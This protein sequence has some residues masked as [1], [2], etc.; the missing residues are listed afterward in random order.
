MRWDRDRGTCS[1]SRAASPSDSE[2]HALSPVRRWRLPVGFRRSGAQRP[3]PGPAQGNS[4]RL[5]LGVTVPVPAAGRPARGCQGSGSAG[6]NLARR[7]RA[8]ARGPGSTRRPRSQTLA[9]G[10]PAESDFRGAPASCARRAFRVSVIMAHSASL[11]LPAESLARS[12][13]FSSA[14][15][16]CF[17][18]ASTLA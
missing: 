13:R 18:S 15:E 9:R 16:R 17:S 1:P 3:D 11:P 8:I 5:G 10:S 7:M 14:K 2:L 6:V 4:L 12:A